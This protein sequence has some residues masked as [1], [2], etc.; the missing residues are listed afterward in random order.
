MAP[1]VSMALDQRVLDAAYAARPV[2]QR[3]GYI[4]WIERAKRPETRMKRVTQMLDELEAGDRY[5]KKEWP[6][7]KV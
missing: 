5:M 1:D 4:A 6:P 7:A 2:G 3:N